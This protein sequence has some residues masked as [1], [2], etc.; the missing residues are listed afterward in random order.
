MEI[1][2]DASDLEPQPSV[3]RYSENTSQPIGGRQVKVSQLITSEHQQFGIRAWQAAIH[4]FHVL[5]QVHVG[6]LTS[7]EI[8]V[9]TENLHRQLQRREVPSG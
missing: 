3:L 4:V 9:P 2:F 5:H 8:S 7:D 6:D 1:C